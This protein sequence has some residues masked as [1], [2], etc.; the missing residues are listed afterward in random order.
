[1][2]YIR[3]RAVIFTGCDYP[4]D[5]L[6]DLRRIADEKCRCTDAPPGVVSE[7]YSG[8]NGYNSFAV[9]PCGSKVGWGLSEKL[10]VVIDELIKLTEGRGIEYGRVQFYDD[11]GVV[12]LKTRDCEVE[13]VMK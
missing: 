4:D 6:S 8:V 11:Q 5:A 9:F 7:V 10:D 12:F 2:G 1:M 3:H 13:K